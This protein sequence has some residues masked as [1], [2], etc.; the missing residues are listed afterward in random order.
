MSEKLEALTPRTLAYSATAAALV[1]ALQ[2]GL[3][4]G[5]VM[6]NFGGGKV[7]MASGPSDRNATGGGSYALV[8][9]APT[10]SIKPW[11][12]TIVPFSRVAPE[13]VTIRALVIAYVCAETDK[14]KTEPIAQAANRRNFNLI[15]FIC[16]Y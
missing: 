3:L 9:F 1:V 16:G 13:T 14:P 7:E 11:R 6:N 8:T 10:A 15:K 2:F 4:T 5:V 12:T